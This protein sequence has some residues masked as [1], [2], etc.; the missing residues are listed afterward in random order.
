M[1]I[2]WI[3][4]KASIDLCSSSHIV[5]LLHHQ[6][7][8]PQPSHRESSLFWHQGE[9]AINKQCVPLLQYSAHLY[10]MVN[11][12]LDSV[13]VTPK[14]AFLGKI[15]EC[16]NR[17]CHT[18]SY[19]LKFCNFSYKLMKNYFILLRLLKMNLLFAIKKY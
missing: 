8:L 5:L 15:F 14:T 4:C 17:H 13:T 11:L 1:W 19:K 9:Q 6:L 2:R 3:I 7:L 18:F 16:L 12:C 10:S